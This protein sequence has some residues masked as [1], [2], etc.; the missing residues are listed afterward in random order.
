MPTYV[1]RRADGSRFELFQSITAPPLTTCPTTNQ[2]VERVIS[3]G[4][5]FILKGSGFYQTDYVS[6]PNGMD[7][8]E[9]AKAEDKEVDVPADEKPKSKKEPAETHESA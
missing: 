3:G 9:N 8:A 7:P 2:S 1:Y 5:G 4:T 6:R